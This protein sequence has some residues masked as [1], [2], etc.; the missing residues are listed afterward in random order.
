MMKIN[1]APW[2]EQKKQYVDDAPIPAT[3]PTK[4]ELALVHVAGDGATTKGWGRESFMD[5]YR[6][7]KFEPTGYLRRFA[8]GRPFGFVMR[9]VPLFCVDI[10]PKHGG[11]QSAR[12]LALPPTLAETSRSGN[13]FHLFYKEPKAT[14]DEKYGFESLPDPNGLLPGIDIRSTG[15][16]YHYPQQRWN[17]L[18]P[19]KPPPGILRLLAERKRMNEAAIAR[20]AAY[21]DLDPVD[22]AMYAD[23]LLDELRKFVPEG[24]RN[25]VLYSWGCKAD[26]VVKDWPLHLYLRG[27]Q[28]GLEEYELTQLIRSVQK[29]GRSG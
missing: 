16:V 24:R 29:R 9:A 20:T 17:D 12:I 27:E 23:E 21:K 11:L 22:R 28:L 5:N 14:W 2:Y 8:H 26:G 18:A 3:W 6:A 10:D 19:A 15:I 1:S 13:G 25:T 7:G 4:R